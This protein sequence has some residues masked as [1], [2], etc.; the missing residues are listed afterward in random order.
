MYKVGG[1]TAGANAR[2]VAFRTGNPFPLIVM[3]QF[4][5]NDCYNGETAVHNA[6][7]QWHFNGGGGTEWY[8][9]PNAQYIDFHNLIQNTAALHEM[10]A[11]TKIEDYEEDKD[12]F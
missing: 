6:V 3:A 7:V 11:E 5:V 12:R 10:E 4:A 9:V 8:S 2:R 1:T